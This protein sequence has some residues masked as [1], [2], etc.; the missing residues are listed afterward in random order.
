[1][2]LAAPT[3][4][5]ITGIIVV[6]ARAA[7]AAFCAVH[8]APVRMMISHVV[9]VPLHDGLKIYLKARSTRP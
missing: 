1:M 6:A 9:F 3:A 7:L 5:T 4:M 2:I 8:A